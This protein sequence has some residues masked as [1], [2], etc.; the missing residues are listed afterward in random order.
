MH[1]VI[2]FRRH[3]HAETYSTANAMVEESGDLESR[4]NACLLVSDMAERL[5]RARSLWIGG[6]TLDWHE[7]TPQQ[8][9]VYRQEIERLVRHVDA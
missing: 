9:Y 5:Y 7:L 8:R 4:L 1:D 6:Q 2:A 3:T